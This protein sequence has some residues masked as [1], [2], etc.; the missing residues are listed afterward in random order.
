M[1]IST[2]AEDAIK[3]FING[4]PVEEALKPAKAI[5]FELAKYAK[6]GTNTL[7]IAYEAFGANNGDKEMGDLKGIEF[8][9]IGSDAQKRRSHCFLANP[10]LCG[11]HA[12]TGRRPGFCRRRLESGVLPGIRF[13]GRTGSGIHVVPDGI[14]AAWGRT[15]LDGALETDLRG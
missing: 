4:K 11:A 13:S 9:R 10:A 1:F 7:E 8:V 2:F 12:R 5:D 14:C 3:V 15:G 6:A